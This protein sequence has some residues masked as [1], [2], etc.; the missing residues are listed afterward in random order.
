[1]DKT[2]DAATGVVKEWYG[3]LV[4]GGLVKQG[5][6]QMALVNNPDYPQVNK[7]YVQTPMYTLDHD[8]PPVATGAAWPDEVFNPWAPPKTQAAPTSKT[9]E[10]IKAQIDKLQEEYD[11]L[12]RTKLSNEEAEEVGKIVDEMKALGMYLGGSRQKLKDSNPFSL[13]DWDFHSQKPMAGEFTP[14]SKYIYDHFEIQ[15]GDEAVDYQDKFFY[16][17]HKHVD[18]PHITVIQNNRLSLYK[19]VWEQL[20]TDYWIN[21]VWKSSPQIKGLL[22]DPRELRKFKLRNS[23]LF[24]MLHDMV[25]LDYE[26]VM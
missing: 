23:A 5:G 8:V 26:D 15:D 7:P 1:M 13:R 12:T 11:R 3:G 9:P 6:S 18:F 4:K 16:S 14:A 24:N 22:K 21:Y 25:E 17:Y 2:K 19:K 10:E 20:P